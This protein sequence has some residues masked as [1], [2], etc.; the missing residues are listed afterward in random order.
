MKGVKIKYIY[1]FF[2][3]LLKT[4]GPTLNYV[5]F[6]KILRQEHKH[7]KRLEGEERERKREREREEERER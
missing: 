6:C 1:M 2:V 5:N 4:W 7:R 3:D